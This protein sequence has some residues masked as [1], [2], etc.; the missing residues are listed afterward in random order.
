MYY[1]ILK[2]YVLTFV[3]TSK[4]MLLKFELQIQR[5]EIIAD[6]NKHEVTILHLLPCCH[7]KHIKLLII[8]NMQLTLTTV[9][10][11]SWYL[12]ILFHLNTI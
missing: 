5:I 4:I 1:I 2:H 3:W 7:I 6:Q 11:L 9:K 10:T 12:V 8:I